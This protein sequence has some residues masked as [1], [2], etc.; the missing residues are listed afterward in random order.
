VVDAATGVARCA[1]VGNTVTR[2]FGAREGR[3]Y[4]VAGTLGHQLR[5]PR[6]QRLALEPGDVL[7]LYSD[8]VKEGFDAAAY[9]E[10][11]TQSPGT[12]AR[13]LVQRFGKDHDDAGCVVVKRAR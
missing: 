7:V 10:L 13:T 2:L 5:T 3:V 8:G 9:P 4:S 12:I 11:R 6:E 1:G